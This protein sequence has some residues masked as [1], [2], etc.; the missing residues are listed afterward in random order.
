LFLKDVLILNEHLKKK[1]IQTWMW[2]DMLISPDEVPS[3][4]PE[5]MHGSMAGYGKALRDK[6]PRDIVI[7]DW[8]YLDDQPYFPSLYM[9]RQ[10]GFKVIGTT[11]KKE[12]TI[13]NFSLY[14]AKHGAEGMIATT[15]SHV[16]R[17]EWDVVER[18]IRESGEAFRKDFP[19]AK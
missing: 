17:K 2:G 5:Q 10:E 1:G 15:W 14:A 6:L 8:H 12:K 19:D 4:K 11:W 9:F 7:C 16:Q 18:I 3:M 13:H